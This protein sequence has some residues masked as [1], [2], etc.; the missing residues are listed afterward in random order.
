MS[1]GRFGRM[2]HAGGTNR[3]GD[4]NREN[5]DDDTRLRRDR[6][7]DRLV[8]GAS[9]IFAVSASVALAMM[10]P[11]LETGQ[12]AGLSIYAFGLLSMFTCSALYNMTEQTGTHGLFRR[13]DH[14]AIFIM[15]A[16]TYTPLTLTL[17]PTARGYAV[18]TFVWTGA[19]A[20]AFVK[21]FF[22]TRFERFSVAAYLVLGWAILAAIGPLS[23]ALPL[24]GLL[25][26][27]AGGFF[28]SFGV[29]FHLA[30]RL[31]YQNALWHACVLAGAAC[32]FAMI[33]RFVAGR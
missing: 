22:P 3:A 32:H 31:P 25:L 15:I 20:G 1:A 29:I 18:L 11:R 7:A 10:F 8:H 28:Y 24:P 33:W 26:L 21:L 14:A 30:T 17:M 27:A 13:L 23:K 4:V 19:I 12:V 2:S 5:F 9:L 16:G 6:A